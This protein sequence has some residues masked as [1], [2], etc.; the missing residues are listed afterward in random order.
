MKLLVFAITFAPLL[1]WWVRSE[2]LLNKLRRTGQSGTLPDTIEAL[3]AGFTQSG[4]LGTFIGIAIGLWSFNVEQIEESVPPL[5]EGLTSA[6]L[7]S[8]FGI[9]FA[10]VYRSRCAATWA[11]SLREEDAPDDRTESD[12]LKDLILATQTGFSSMSE[13]IDNLRKGLIGDGDGTLTTVMTKMR[14]EAIDA[15][16]ENRKH[17]EG[18]VSSLHNGMK[19][20]HQ[21]TLS[22]IAGFSEELAKNN[23][24]LLVDAMTGA[25]DAFNEQ[26]STI[27]ER[28]VK[29]NF[30]ELNK[31]V[32]RM[33]TWQ[34]ENKEMVGTMTN[35]FKEVIAGVQKTDETL[36]GIGGTVDGI[37][38]QVADITQRT[39]ELTDEGGK[40]QELLNSLSQVMVEEDKFSQ[41]ADK[42][43]NAVKNIDKSTNSFTETS[44][45]L[46]EW[47]S[48]QKEFRKSTK[49]LIKK[50]EEI[51]KIKDM[52][53]FFWKDV[54][55]KLTE[56]SD[57][58]K[59]SNRM[60]MKNLEEINKEFTKELNSMLKSLDRYIQRIVAEYND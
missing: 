5:L 18:Q 7:T 43:A 8:I 44:T 49:E 30:D 52:N 19:E 9:I 50:F 38:T 22:A 17:L 21:E 27:V 3:P 10:M 37:T 51:A 16:Q 26:M 59:D 46:T 31:S 23:V 42:L 28:L 39:A 11:K 4:V 25:V 54:K 58:I 20:Q 47:T 6:F 32:D 60:L 33:N 35:Q 45:K 40:L 53:E 24:D 14:I 13:S 36:R 15:A 48:D 1:V 41:L 57:V 29:E 12:I 2:F 55:S 56:G 34:Q